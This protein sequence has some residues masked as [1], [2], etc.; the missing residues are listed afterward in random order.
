MIRLMEMAAAAQAD[1]VFDTVDP[2]ASHCL[3]RVVGSD[4]TE[5]SQSTVSQ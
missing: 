5:S 4:H 2:S 3:E 1:W